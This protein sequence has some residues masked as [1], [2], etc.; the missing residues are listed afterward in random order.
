MTAGRACGPEA[1]PHLQARGTSPADIKAGRSQ[2]RR[3]LPV[4]QLDRQ[5]DGQLLLEEEKK[6][7]R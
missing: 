6:Q 2:K 5:L 4:G 1:H 7:S 3:R